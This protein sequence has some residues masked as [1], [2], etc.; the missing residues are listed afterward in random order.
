M[1][2]NV[3]P[4]DNPIMNKKER[5][6]FI[7]YGK[8]YLLRKI[9][10]KHKNILQITVSNILVNSIYGRKTIR[11]AIPTTDDNSI[12]CIIFI[13]LHLFSMLHKFSL[14]SA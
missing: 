12:V 4:L 9:A 3:F 7:H 10:K 1:N 11:T 14:F 6:F 5:R 8:F 2:R 13:A